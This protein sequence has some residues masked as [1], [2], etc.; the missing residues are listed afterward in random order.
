MRLGRSESCVAGPAGEGR[1]P[2]G[3]SPAARSILN[4]NDTA[5]PASA[6][7]W[8]FRP[9]AMPDSQAGT[10]GRPRRERGPRAAARAAARGR[11]QQSWQRLGRGPLSD[12]EAN[13][14]ECE[15]T[16]VPSK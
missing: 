1:R 16:V 10:E 12:S 9:W 11:E 14:Q 3:R 4:L 6:W 15:R 5:A 13:F 2:G 7:Q 8:H